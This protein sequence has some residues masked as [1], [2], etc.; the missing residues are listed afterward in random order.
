[1]LTRLPEVFRT[2]RT[3]HPNVDLQLREMHSAAQ[4][5][6]LKAGTIDVAI[7]REVRTDAGI[8]SLVVV[9]ERFAAVLP[10]GHPLAERHVIPAQALAGEPFIVCRRAVAPVLHDQMAAICADA[11]FTPAIR[12]EADEWHTVF[13]FVRAGF[14]VSLAPQ[15]LADLSGT[16]VVFRPLDRA[17]VLAELHLCWARERASPAVRRFIETMQQLPAQ[18]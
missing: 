14:G 5:D 8:G 3:T 10:E 7:T 17:P 13:G 6:S 12:Q 2:F 9:Q 18:G 11:G 1:M 15:G 4:W 16:G